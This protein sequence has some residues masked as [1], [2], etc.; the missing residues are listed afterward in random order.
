[1]TAA[2]M[3]AGAGLSSSEFTN[4]VSANSLSGISYNLKDDSNFII[5]GINPWSWEIGMLDF[6]HGTEIFLNTSTL[7]L[8]SMSGTIEEKPFSGSD[9][10]FERGY[11]TYAE[12][13]EPSVI[14][15]FIAG[16]CL[17]LLKERVVN[18][19]PSLSNHQG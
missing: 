14:I 2:E 19:P 12:I 17:F 8:G 4:S 16:V 15:L 5:G 6:N 3:Q 7:P 11:W 9:L 13:P 1:V 18:R 10:F